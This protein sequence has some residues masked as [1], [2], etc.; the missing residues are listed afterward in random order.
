MTKASIGNFD[1]KMAEMTEPFMAPWAD[2]AWGPHFSPL[3]A[4]HSG[5]RKG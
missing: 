1:M 3:G 4:L 2:I 5:P